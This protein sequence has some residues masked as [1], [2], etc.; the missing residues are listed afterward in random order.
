MSEDVVSEAPGHLT[1][2]VAGSSG[3]Y[4]RTAEAKLLIL[5]MLVWKQALAQQSLCHPE[6][7]IPW[8]TD[9]SDKQ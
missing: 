7:S 4:K 6:L 2:V 9:L 3:L 5:S 8:S 1:W